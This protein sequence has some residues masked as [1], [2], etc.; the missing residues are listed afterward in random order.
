MHR[1]E[2]IDLG[3]YRGDDYFLVGFVEPAPTES[4]DYDPD[5]D[6]ENY[7]V[8]LAR[9]GTYSDGGNVEIVRLDTAHE[10]PHVDLLYLPSDAEREQK[11]LLEDGYTYER[12]KTYLLANWKPF[13][14]RYARQH[15]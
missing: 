13:A 7:G 5:S 6:A 14:D 10:R 15:E 8:T 2:T 11:V 4:E 3:T 1:F 12:M 9:S